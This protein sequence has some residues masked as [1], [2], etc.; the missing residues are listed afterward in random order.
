MRHF[1]SHTVQPEPILYKVEISGFTLEEACT[2]NNDVWYNGDILMH[3]F[4][5]MAISSITLDGQ[6][7]KKWYK[8]RA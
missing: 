7:G 3:A 5:I 1:F 4:Q 8:Y 2:N 6:T